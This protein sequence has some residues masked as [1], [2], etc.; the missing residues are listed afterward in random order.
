MEAE[1]RAKR[2]AEIAAVQRRRPKTKAKTLPPSP[3]DD[4][5]TAS[6]KTGARA[7]LILPRAIYQTF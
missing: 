1:F 5:E 3:G 2:E 6:K 4:S 7:N